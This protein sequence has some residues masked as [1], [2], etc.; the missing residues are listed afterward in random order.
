MLCQE[1]K[2]APDPP[3]PGGPGQMGLEEWARAMMTRVFKST[4]RYYDLSSFKI[5]GPNPKPH[6]PP[7]LTAAFKLI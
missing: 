6:L 3:V 2:E 5:V 4:K 1:A 7:P